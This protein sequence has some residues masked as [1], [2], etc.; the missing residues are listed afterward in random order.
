M[1]VDTSQCETSNIFEWMGGG[2]GGGD[3]GGGN[4]NVNS[5]QV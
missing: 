2:G 3:L 4:E 1:H 5:K